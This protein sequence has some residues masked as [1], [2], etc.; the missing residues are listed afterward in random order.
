MAAEP[1]FPE[2]ARTVRKPVKVGKY[3]FLSYKSGIATFALW[4]RELD[5]V[6]AHISFQDTTYG[7]TFRG[8]AVLSESGKAKRFRTEQ[9]AL[10]AVVKMA[11][12]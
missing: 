9:T 8:K 2:S 6:V 3:T 10:N 12:K 11:G 4:C 1:R 5:A 7:A